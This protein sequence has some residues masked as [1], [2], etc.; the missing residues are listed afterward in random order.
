[1]FIRLQHSHVDETTHPGLHDEHHVPLVERRRVAAQLP[2]LFIV[3]GDSSPPVCL[4]LALSSRGEQCEP[5]STGA[6]CSVG[7]RPHHTRKPASNQ[8]AHR[9]R[10]RKNST[11]LPCHPKASGSSPVRSFS[12]NMKISATM[13]TV[14]RAMPMASCGRVRWPRTTGPLP[15]SPVNSFAIAKAPPFTE[16][17]RLYRR[18]FPF[19]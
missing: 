3:H 6:P 5:Q 4:T 18:C 10:P 14:N 11:S 19:S 9:R 2:A 8:P 15:G 12:P 16:N 13:M 1:M 17:K 7:G